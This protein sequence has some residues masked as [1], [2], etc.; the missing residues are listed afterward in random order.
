MVKIL[1]KLLSKRSFS[2]FDFVTM[3][4]AMMLAALDGDVS[5]EELVS[6][7][8]MAS[9]CRG[10]TPQSFAKL[11]DEA[12]RSA[13]YLLV[14]S[15][16]LPED[17]LIALFVREA[18]DSFVEEVSAEVS[19]DRR[20]AFDVLAEMAAADGDISDVESRA[21]KALEASVKK[22]REEIIEM[23]YPRAVK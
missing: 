18:T 23:L 22:R 17:E 4:T 5:A 9:G 1:K 15:K 13:G 3:K 7:R 21:I 16:I 6:F 10:C 8:D 11:W 14:Q 20:H 2:A 12:L 19:E